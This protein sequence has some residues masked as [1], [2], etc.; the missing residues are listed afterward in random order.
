ML[1]A[2]HRPM[3]LPPPAE[4]CPLFC[5]LTPPKGLSPRSPAS[6]SATRDEGISV[7]SAL[8]SH[9]LGCCWTCPP[10]TPSSLSPAPSGCAF[11]D[12][13]QA[14]SLSL[15]LGRHNWAVAWHQCPSL[16]QQL[17]VLLLNA[18]LC[19][20]W[21]S[22]WECGNLGQ[23]TNPKLNHLMPTFP[24]IAPCQ[25]NLSS[26]TPL[27][28]LPQHSPMQQMASLVRQVLTPETWAL[29]PLLPLPPL[30]PTWSPYTFLITSALLPMARAWAPFRPHLQ[31]PA[32]P[33]GGLA[34]DCPKPS[35]SPEGP[36]GRLD[37]C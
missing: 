10:L 4:V 2:T 22:P 11:P 25:V 1:P 18:H 32:P 13:L 17:P 8:F 37:L 21:T 31:L 33:R 9:S 30:H 23:L 35:S 26:C 14:V 12:P 27:L 24:Q 19:P 5:P 34:S 29:P 7:F 28:A 20:Y 15:S 36:E 3:L 16:C 6:I